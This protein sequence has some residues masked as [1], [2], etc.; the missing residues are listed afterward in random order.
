MATEINSLH[1]GPGSTK[2]CT[3]HQQQKSSKKGGAYKTNKKGKEAAYPT[4]LKKKHTRA[5]T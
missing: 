4:A 3:T 5:C 2:C 1:S